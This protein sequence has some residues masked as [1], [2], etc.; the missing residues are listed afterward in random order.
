MQSLSWH[1][2]VLQKEQREASLTQ[3]ILWLP[4]Q[5]KRNYCIELIALCLEGKKKTKVLSHETQKDRIYHL[6]IGLEGEKVHL[7]DYYPNFCPEN[8]GLR[9]VEHQLLPQSRKPE[10]KGCNWVL[11]LFFFFLILLFLLKKERKQD[12]CTITCSEESQWSIA[13]ASREVGLDSRGKEH[14]ALR[15]L[16]FWGWAAE[17]G[18]ARPLHDTRYGRKVQ[19]ALN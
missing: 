17:L 1:P 9:T 14:E 8:H 7:M 10:V 16:R 18:S 13:E 15:T 12:N 11:L 3:S 5:G 2:R 4:G 6:E 19:M